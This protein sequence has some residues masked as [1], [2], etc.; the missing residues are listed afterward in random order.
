MSGGAT[1]DP[2]DWRIQTRRPDGTTLV[3]SASDLKI[4]GSDINNRD[5][6]LISYTLGITDPFTLDGIQV[7]LLNGNNGN[8]ITLTAISVRVQRIV[9]PE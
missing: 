1:A 4:S 7:G 8:T 2:K 9:N 5:A 3:G 6:A